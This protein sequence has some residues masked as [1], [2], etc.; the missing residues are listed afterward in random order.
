MISNKEIIR[1]INRAQ[2]LIEKEDNETRD[3]F[4]KLINSS[5]MEQLLEKK[6]DEYLDTISGRLIKSLG[7]GSSFIMKTIHPIVI[8]MD[9]DIAKIYINMN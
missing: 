7:F 1:V 2:R 4:K 8:N 5:E 6:I 3:K 9:K